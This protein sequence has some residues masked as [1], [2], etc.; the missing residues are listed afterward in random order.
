MGIFSSKY[1]IHASTVT[2]KL[3]DKYENPLPGIIVSSVISGDSVST[4]MNQYQTTGIYSKAMS[5]YRYGESS[6]IRGLPTGFLRNTNADAG[7]VKDL[8]ESEVENKIEILFISYDEYLHEHYIYV[9]LQNE[10]LRNYTT[11]LLGVNPDGL[12]GEVFYDSW[13]QIGL[14]DAL[15][16]NYKNSSDVYVGNEVIDFTYTDNLAYQVIYR[17][18]DDTLLP[19]EESL[20][21][22]WIA[23]E[24][25]EE[26]EPGDNLLPEGALVADTQS[27]YFPI[28]PFFEDK[29]EIGS[30]AAIVANDP[31]YVS[32]KKC[33]KKLG[34]NFDEL[35][36]NIKEGTDESIGSDK[37][38]Y[39]YFQ[40]SA[41][42][43]AGATF[44]PNSELPEEGILP[45]IFTGD[46]ISKT[47]DHQPTLEY[48]YEFF[49]TEA[50]NSKYDKNDFDNSYKFG[51]YKKEPKRNSIS[52]TDETYKLTFS[53]FYIS[54]EVIS[55]S[56]TGITNWIT[57]EVHETNFE[58]NTLRA[59]PTNFDSSTLIIRKE[60]S[61]FAYKEIRIC[62]LTQEFII[63]KNKTSLTYL[64]DAFK[65]EDPLFM[66]IPLNL[67]IVKK[68]ASSKRNQLIHSSMC[69]LINSYVIEEIKWYQTGLFKTVLTIISV[70]LAPFSGGA[71]LTL[72]S[73][74]R[75]AAYFIVM[76]LLN[77]FVVV[78]ILKYIAKELGPKAAAILATLM[79]VVGAFKGMPYAG[80]IAGAGR[81]MF[82]AIDVMYKEYMED[83]QK[84]LMKL[85]S[86]SDK[87]NDELE[88]AQGLL[89]NEMSLDPME[90]F[91]NRA[92]VNWGESPEEYITSKLQLPALTLATSQTHSIYV[93]LMVR[94]PSA[95]ETLNIR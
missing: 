17:I 93:D 52:I 66:A 15:R 63:F 90:M 74:L 29:T 54:T 85:R 23:I 68:V 7:A 24:E 34:L 13:D 41:E 60:L 1:K 83:L 33:L 26:T 58:L 38:L 78:P 51:L 16:I 77:K 49:S 18:L 62:G 8:I 50:N 76:A 25:D 10:R 88:R 82:Q 47:K 35:S 87:L 65:E 89:D 94:L 30:P 9:Y 69:L 11:G 84:D 37:G 80:Y 67:G 48:L 79:V 56:I 61:P 36:A 31:L 14:T 22:Y 92:T 12:T 43:T 20:P 86:E 72:L 64:S 55:G 42:V 70:V 3:M 57:S 2:T 21:I 46:T 91:T 75:I 40:L 6:F 44:I 27:P 81:A 73:V 19:E 4:R 45:P 5:Y 53:Y 59:G 71:S 32:G 39:V 95:N 28:I